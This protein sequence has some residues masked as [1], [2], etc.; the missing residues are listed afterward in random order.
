MVPSPIQDMDIVVPVVMGLG[1][2]VDHPGDIFDE[3][4]FV[5]DDDLGLGLAVGAVG[6]GRDLGR[7]LI[8]EGVDGRGVR[9][10]RGRRW[11]VAAKGSA[12]NAA[13]TE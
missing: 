1:I 5:I 7:R 11:A 4:V 10:G 3:V 8:D 13:R 6:Q 12:A 2:G 9:R